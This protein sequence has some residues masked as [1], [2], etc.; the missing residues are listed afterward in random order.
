MKDILCTV[1]YGIDD[2]KDIDVD[3][4]SFFQQS[5]YTFGNII[6]TVVKDVDAGIGATY[7]DTEYK[8]NSEHGW[9]YQATLTYNW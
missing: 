8:T 9:R 2:P 7:V 5:Q 4:T 3:G 6:Y 1:G